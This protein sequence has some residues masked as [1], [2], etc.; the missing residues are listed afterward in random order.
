ME[1]AR[2]AG[3][4]PAAGDLEPFVGARVAAPGVEYEEFCRQ[5][6]E[7][8]DAERANALA[9][10]AAETLERRLIDAIEAEGPGP[11]V[12]SLLEALPPTNCFVQ[13]QHR[14]VSLQTPFGAALDAGAAGLALEMVRRLEPGWEESAESAGVEL[15]LFRGLGA[16]WES[17]GEEGCW[18]ELFRAIVSLPGEW[19]LE[20]ELGVMLGAEDSAGDLEPFIGALVAAPGFRGW[21]EYE[22]EEL[23]GE[24]LIQ[25]WREY[26]ARVGR[27][28]LAM[29]LSEP[30]KAWM[31]SVARGVQRARQ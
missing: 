12:D 16:A 14:A 21:V 1:Q 20:N 29:L 19:E 24:W 23:S 22:E 13:V 15:V 10:V 18:L 11:E 30:R 6:A 7:R 2:K 9:G 8:A 25:P 4:Q 17:R 27:E 5:R 28:D 3:M 26:A 31:C